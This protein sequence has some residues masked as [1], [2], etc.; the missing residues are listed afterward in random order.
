MD[1]IEKIKEWAPVLIPTLC[2]FSHLKRLIESLEGCVGAS[3]T[4]VYVALDYPLNESQRKGWLQI[5]TYLSSRT[6]GFNKLVVYER[7]RNY[8][9]GQYGNYAKLKADVLKEYSTFIE[10]EDDNVF[11]KNFLIY[12]N[13][14]LNKFM[15]DPSV[16]SIC[17]YRYFYNHLFSD[18]NFFRNQQDFNAWGHA[19]WIDKQKLIENID[20]TYFKNK[21]WDFKAL[22]KVWKAGPVMFSRFLAYSREKSFKKADYFYGLY[23]ILEGKYQIM[24]RVSKVRNHGWDSSGVN[25]NNYPKDIVEKH[26]NQP[27]DESDTFDY[28]GTGFEFFEENRKIMR[29]EDYNKKYSSNFK[30]LCRLIALQFG[31][32]K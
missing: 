12:I 4:D 22:R 14:G 11:S 2:R 10:S 25:C 18:N 1:N 7:K 9:L 13:K 27:I 23:M 5:K 8:G 26:L 30:N 15:D 17:G 21:L 3:Y 32:L 6:F 16:I 31:I 28:I 29:D 20:Y 24:P 19:G